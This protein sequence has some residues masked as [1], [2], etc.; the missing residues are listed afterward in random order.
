MPFTFEVNG[1]DAL[2]KTAGKMIGS[3]TYFGGVE[4]P[5]ELSDW[6]TDD[7]HRHKP[8]TKRSKWRRGSTNVQ[9]VVRPHSRYETERSAQYQKRLLR[10]IRRVGKTKRFKQITDFI[11]LKRSSRPILRESLVQQ[12][13]N[14][15]AQAMQ[16]TIVWK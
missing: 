14:R 5:K 12:L 9:T 16:E 7:M 13:V 10:R 3:I 2:A 6:Q 1:A 4:M 8:G 11:Q 15:M